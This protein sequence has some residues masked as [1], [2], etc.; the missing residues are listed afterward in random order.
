MNALSLRTRVAVLVALGVGIAVTVTSLA[1]FVTVRVQLYR[2]LDQNLLDRAQTVVSSPLG[3]PTVLVRVPPGALGAADV[4]VAIVRADGSAVSARGARDAPPLGAEEVAVASGAKEQSTRTARSGDGRFRVVAVPAAPGHALVL[5]QSTAATDRTL[6]ALG[7]VLL[8]VGLAG[9]AQAAWA[10]VLVARQ[11]LA[12]VERLTGAAEH[13]ARTEDLR[14]IAVEGDDELARL[15]RA[16]NAMLEALALSRERQRRLVADA[17]H[18]LRTPL[19]SL[20]T[21]LDLLAQSEQQAGLSPQD[22]A[23]LLADVRAQVEEL[24]GLVSD[25]VEL[26]REDSPRAAGEPVDLADVVGRA[27]E[28]ARR[29]APHVRFELAAQ[30]WTVTGDGQALER[31]VLNLLDNAGKW[32]PPGGTVRVRLRDGVVSVADEG[33]GI[34]AKDLPFIF[35]RFYRSEAARTMPGSGL[36][37]AIVRQAAERH[38][39]SVTAGPAPAGGAVVT[40]AIP[41]RSSPSHG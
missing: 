19:T 10:G 41:G 35:D 12:P 39:G 33:P 3:D 24:T 29:R 16:F 28:R 31:A 36:G 32:S 21:N 2:Q 14:P 11:G 40:L 18:E 27:V 23:D 37:L 15:G 30:P 25:L 8:V 13:V 5:G 20:R 6:G 38:G 26:A 22:R 7:L 17:G 4:R 34:A 9:V 1:A